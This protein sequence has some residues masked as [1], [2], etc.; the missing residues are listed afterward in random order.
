MN[1]CI[2][3]QAIEEIK[4]IMTDIN[5]NSVYTARMSDIRALSSG[6]RTGH[7]IN[8]G[9]WIVGDREL[10][11]FKCSVCDKDTLEK[12][13]FCPHCGVKMV[14]KEADNEQRTMERRRQ[15]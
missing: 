15:L 5:G 14:K 13:N 6:T 10:P 12:E 7:W 2:S 3:R 4:E 11:I 8:I 1:D 9:A